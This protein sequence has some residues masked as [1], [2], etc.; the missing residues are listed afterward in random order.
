MQS[1]AVSPSRSRV[2]IA[3]EP[4]I[5]LLATTSPGEPLHYLYGTPGLHASYFDVD[6]RHP[7]GSTARARSLAADMP[8]SLGAI[9]RAS[10]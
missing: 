4:V 5:D 9:S 1:G 10:A 7:C 6:R 3:L 2:S 8:E